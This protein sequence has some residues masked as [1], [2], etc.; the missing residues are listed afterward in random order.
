MNWNWRYG[1][2]AT[3]NKPASRPNRGKLRAL[4]DQAIHDS[5]DESDEHAGLLSMIREEVACPFPA[6]VDGKDV[7]CIRFDW[8]SKGYGLNAVCNCKDKG[9]T[10]VVDIS[11]LEWTEPRPQGYE[12]IEAY[13]AWLDLIG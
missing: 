3:L 12:W 4:I 11:K 10:L 6:R 7:E 5:V 2:S 13:F 9:N 8:P 1:N